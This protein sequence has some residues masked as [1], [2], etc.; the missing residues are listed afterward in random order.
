MP[1][2]LICT[3]ICPPPATEGP[4][5][6]GGPSVRFKRR[7][8][9]HSTF[10]GTILRVTILVFPSTMEILCL[11]GQKCSENR[12]RG[13]SYEEGSW[14]E[15]TASCAGRAQRWNSGKQGLVR[16]GQA[17]LLAQAL[18]EGTHGLLSPQP[19]SWCAQG[20]PPAQPEAFGL[21]RIPIRCISADGVRWIASCVNEYC[22]NTDCCVDSFV[23]WANIMVHSAQKEAGVAQHIHQFYR[24]MTFV[25]FSVCTR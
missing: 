13:V 6:G 11:T 25:I 7:L 2:S 15:Q 19:L 16:R 22:P 1:P 4:P 3:R 20:K 10:L 9:N 24:N 8:N 18:L 5:L 21:Q 14:N 17:P 23:K 12:K